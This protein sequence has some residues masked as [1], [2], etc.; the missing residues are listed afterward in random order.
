MD[1][2]VY[3]ILDITL[4]T[5]LSTADLTPNFSE[6]NYIYPYYKWYNL[7]SNSAKS[8]AVLRIII[9]ALDKNLCYTIIQLLAKFNSL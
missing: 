3:I 7:C 8:L 5:P 9:Q 1:N 6:S 4:V 2:N